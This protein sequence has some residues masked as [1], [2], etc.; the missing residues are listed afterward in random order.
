VQ[1]GV[2]T[3]NIRLIAQGERGAQGND[4]ASWALDRRVD[5]ELGD[6]TADN[7]GAANNLNASPSPILEGT[8]MDG[9]SPDPA[10][11]KSKGGAS[12]SNTAEGGKE[13]GSA[14]KGSATGK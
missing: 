7:N 2:L 9:L 5:F 8:R 13:T 3:A 14:A 10:S 12:Y 1:R 11:P 4:E 6:R